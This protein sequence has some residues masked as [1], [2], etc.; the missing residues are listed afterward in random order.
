MASIYKRGKVWWINWRNSCG[1]RSCESLK[2]KDQ[3]IARRLKKHYEIEERRAV[4]RG[5]I[6]VEAIG[7]E[8]YISEYLRSRDG[9][10]APSTIT[11]YK[12]VLT[13]LPCS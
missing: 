7:L 12:Q 13:W 2:T 8:S 9:Q 10:V 4:L 6:T 3:T 1:R 11:R 5:G